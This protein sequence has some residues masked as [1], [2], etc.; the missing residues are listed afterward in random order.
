LSASGGEYARRL[1]E[2]KLIILQIQ[3]PEGVTNAE[4]IASV[5]GYDFLMFGPGDFAH[6]IGKIGQIDSPEVE[7]ARR[8]M[9]AAAAGHGKMGFY[10]GPRTKPADLLQRGYR[11]TTLGSDVRVLG[12]SMQSLLKGFHANSV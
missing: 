4:E 7:E 2:E 5:P 9:E 12:S 6:R 1:N 10:T 8:K 11:A 3:S